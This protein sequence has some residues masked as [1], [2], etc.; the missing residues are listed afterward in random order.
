MWVPIMYFITFIAAFYACC[1]FLI[2]NKK[3]SSQFI[4]IGILV[5]IHSLGK[6]T[7][8]LSNSLEMA[9]WAARFMNLGSVFCPVMLIIIIKNLCGQKLSKFIEYPFIIFSII[10]FLFSIS[11]GAS[12]IY[13][14]DLSIDTSEGYTY[15]VKSYG[16]GYYI[17]PILMLIC[18]IFLIYYITYAI[19]HR[20]EISYLSIIVIC[21][22]PTIVVVIYLI[23]L[24]T[25]SHVSYL[26]I[27]YLMGSIIIKWLFTRQQMFDMTANLATSVDRMSEYGYIEIDMKN[28]YIK[29]NNIIKELFPEIDE[30]YQVDKPIPTINSTLYDDVLSWA[31]NPNYLEKDKNLHFNDR[32]YHVSVRDIFYGRKKVGYLIEFIDRTDE[33]KYTEVIK[34]YNNDLKIEVAKKT[35]ALRYARDRLVIGM[36]E[37]AESRDSSTGEHIK[38]TS[39]TVEVFSNYMLSK[40]NPYNLTPSFL[41]MVAK[42]APMHDLG[43]V[44]IDDNILR[45]PGKL[46]DEEFTEMKKHSEAGA[47]IIEKVLRGAGDDEFVDIARNI[48]CYHH[49]KWNGKGYPAGLKGEEI[50]VEARIMTLVDVFDALVSKR[51]YKAAFSYD[52]AFSIIEEGLGSQFDPILGQEFINCR[53]SIEELY[54]HNEH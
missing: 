45:K 32:Y 36:A 27:G 47:Q 24:I 13:F 42:A 43:K 40:S 18:L 51:C 54:N 35:E 5:C 4:L 26:S 46:T 14:K 25:A 44:T 41:K 7:I 12:D 17:Y 9:I 8:S 49:E 34:N 50:P 20:N 33:Y 16:K 29:A 22:I 1:S 52:Q 15:I 53:Q 21:S 28:R 23:E 2:K 19:R 39:L 10:T 11:I 31:L 37:M 3:I 38:R 30:K 48:A 6:L